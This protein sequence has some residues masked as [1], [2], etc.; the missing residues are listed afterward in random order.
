MK[1]TDLL[2]GAGMIL[3]FLPFF[4][5]S[6][7]YNFYQQVNSSN[8]YMLSFLKFAILATFGEMIGSRIKTGKYCP[9]GFGI[10][11]RAIVWGILGMFIKLNFVIFGAG[12]PKVLTSLGIPTADNILG[13]AFSA[14]K[15]LT[16]FTVSLTLNTFFAPVMMTMHKITDA[17]IEMTGGSLRR[18]FSVIQ[19]RTIL[20]KVNWK[21]LWGFVFKKTIPIFWIPAQTINFLLP[22]EYRVLV[23]AIYSIIL[24]IFLAIASLKKS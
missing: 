15:L 4:V 12:A 22:E 20:E 2:Y 11:P 3:L 7:V 8:P 24:G 17:H 16:A 23:A 18:F 6:N 5:F 13:Q 21:S 1:K 19:V 14:H 10:L 9:S